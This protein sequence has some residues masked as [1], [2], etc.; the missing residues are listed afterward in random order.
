MFLCNDLQGNV[1][2]TKPQNYIG[3]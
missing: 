3:F 2:I 1:S